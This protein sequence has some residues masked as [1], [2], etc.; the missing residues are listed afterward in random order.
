[1]SSR[2]LR[3]LEKK[4]MEDGQEKANKKPGITTRS[5]SIFTSF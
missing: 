3:R 4:R 1:M 2:L 5:R